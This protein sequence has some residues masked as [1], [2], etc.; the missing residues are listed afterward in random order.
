[1]ICGGGGFEWLAFDKVAGIVDE[2]IQPPCRFGKPLNHFVYLTLVSNVGLE[3]D[4]IAVLFHFSKRL[5][6]S[7][8]CSEIMNADETALSGKFDS[9]CLPYA[10][11]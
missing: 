7:L 10:G 3:K 2:N 6:A 5:L 8:F 1:M 11:A 9:C 4:A